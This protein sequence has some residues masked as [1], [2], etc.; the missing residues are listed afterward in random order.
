MIKFCAGGFG[1]K[2]FVTLLVT[3]LVAVPMALG[4]L[5]GFAY[6]STGDDVVPRPTVTAMETRLTL[7]DYTWNEPV[8]AGLVRRDFAA[9][10]TED[11]QDLGTFTEPGI[12]LAC[13]EGY[14]SAATILYGDEAVWQGAAEDIAGA[15]LLDD[16]EYRL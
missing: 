14:T 3:L 16:G 6:H 4:L 13:P 9:T 7:R 2:Q 15:V 1:V 8:M 11:F 10:S 5:A 12:S